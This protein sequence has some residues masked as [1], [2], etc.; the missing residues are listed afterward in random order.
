M[1]EYQQA[2]QDIETKVALGASKNH[3][4]TRRQSLAVSGGR[5]WPNEQ[6]C[7]SY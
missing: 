4:T 2:T 5:F 7:L 1:G 6:D 3:L